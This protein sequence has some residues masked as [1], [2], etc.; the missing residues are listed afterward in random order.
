MQ[1]Q[2]GLRSL[3]QKCHLCLLVPNCIETCRK[4]PEKS[5]AAR[6]QQNSSVSLLYSGAECS[7]QE[8][9][10]VAFSSQGSAAVT[11]CNGIK[12]SGCAT[13]SGGKCSACAGGF[14]KGPETCRA[15]RDL[16]GFLDPAGHACEHY[17]ATKACE[18]GVISTS[19]FQANFVQ[20]M[21]LED[22]RFA[23][24]SSLFSITVTVLGCFRIL[25]AGHAVPSNCIELCNK[26][27]RALSMRLLR[28]KRCLLCMW[29]RHARQHSFPIFINQPLL[30]AG[31]AHD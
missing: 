5:Q 11:C 22:Y 20:H 3:C 21:Q 8:T 16:P 13:I 19:K 28:C 7:V 26:Q 17:V 29:W 30:C 1:S 2:D 27:S 24:V 10:L 4:M 15:C 18:N 25:W 12:C 14:H 31:R 6:G 23:G 9:T